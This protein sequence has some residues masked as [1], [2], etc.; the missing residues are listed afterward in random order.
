MAD[1]IYRDYAHPNY[2]L[3]SRL[4]S[5]RWDRLNLVKPTQIYLPRNHAHLSRNYKTVCV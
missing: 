5:Y 4:S 2:M 1:C 3:Q